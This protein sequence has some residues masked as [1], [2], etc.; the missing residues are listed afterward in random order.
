[1]NKKQLIVMW[2]G[3]SAIVLLGYSE[4]S[5]RGHV[6]VN[7]DKFLLW[8]LMISLVAGGLII[9]FKDKNPENEQDNGDN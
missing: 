1:M 9:T 3:I 7:W 8:I 4:T 6:G 2:C 5:T